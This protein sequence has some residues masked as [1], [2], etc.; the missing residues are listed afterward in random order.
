MAKNT[1]LIL[2][3]VVAIKQSVRVIEHQ[4]ENL[5]EIKSDVYSIK[6]IIEHNDLQPRRIK[7]K[8]NILYVSIADLR[9]LLSIESC[10]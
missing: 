3:Q 5:T 8:D 6:K 4:T 2:E 1:Y 10:E 9:C 7:I